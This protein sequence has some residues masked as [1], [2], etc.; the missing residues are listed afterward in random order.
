[1]SGGHRRDTTTRPVVP[2]A[3]GMAPRARAWEQPTDFRCWLCCLGFLTSQMGIM[4]KKGRVEL[5][6][7]G[8]RFWLHHQPVKTGK[9][10]ITPT[11]TPEVSRGCNS[12]QE[13]QSAEV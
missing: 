2:G 7:S 9:A 1:M 11:A 6:V 8:Q 3:A 12:S 4:R 10:N 5:A 13:S